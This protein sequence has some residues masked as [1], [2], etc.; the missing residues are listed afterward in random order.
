MLLTG[1]GT[2]QKPQVE[3]RTIKQPYLILPSQLTSR[4]DLP[5]IAPGIS[6][7]DSVGLNADLISL[8]A[9]CNIDRAGIRKIEASR[10]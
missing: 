10:Q 6:Y 8:V 1:C 3:Y 7:G 9:Q 2:Q 5:E 4:I